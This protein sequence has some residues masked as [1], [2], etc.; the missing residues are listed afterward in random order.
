MQAVL[1][2]ALSLPCMA[3]AAEDHRSLVKVVVIVGGGSSGSYAAVRLRE[4]YGKSIALIERES[5]LVSTPPQCRVR[6]RML[7]GLRP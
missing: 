7:T 4:D 6:K 2:A 1:L 3:A 5:I